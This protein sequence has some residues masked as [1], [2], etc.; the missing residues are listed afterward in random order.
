MWCIFS[1]LQICQEIFLDLQK[2]GRTKEQS[3]E[4]STCA[5]VD[6][7]LRVH[8]ACVLPMLTPP[9]AFAVAP[10]PV[11]CTGCEK[12]LADRFIVGTCPHC[13]SDGAGGDQCD[14]CGKLLAVMD[15]IEPRCVPVFCLVRGVALYVCVSML[16]CLVAD[17]EHRVGGMCWFL[18]STL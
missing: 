15:L 1:C 3:I 4:Q 5:H 17:S 7:V 2:Q 16:M 8:K 18:P 11:Y 13:K 12:F 6:S 14:T 9:F 10:L